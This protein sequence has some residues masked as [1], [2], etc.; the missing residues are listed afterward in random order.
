[1][2][3]L[4]S[5]S[6][7]ELLKNLDIDAGHLARVLED[8][9]KKEYIVRSPIEGNRRSLFIQLTNYGKTSLMPHIQHTIDKESSILLNGINDK[10]QKLLIKL[11]NQLEMNM[12][13]ALTDIIKDTAHNE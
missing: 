4:G 12:E 6:Q 13:I 8:F 11:L 10:D 7:K 1:L 3:I 5:C 9:E 2:N